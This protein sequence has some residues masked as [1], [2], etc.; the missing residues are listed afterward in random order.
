TG[1]GVRRAA[2]ASRVREI[3]P[4]SIASPLAAH[5]GS[6]RSTRPFPSSSRQSVQADSLP[7]RVAV[8]V[9]LLSHPSPSTAF[10]S[11]HV[12][13]GSTTPSP[14]TPAVTTRRLQP[15]SVPVLPALSSTTVSVHVPFGSSPRNAERAPSPETRTKGV[16][17]GGSGVSLAGASA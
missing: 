3:L 9:Q 10:P 5:A 17:L 15:R 8:G 7:G 4:T 11:S 12:S 2:S 13:P 6:A 1:G 16:P 14:Q